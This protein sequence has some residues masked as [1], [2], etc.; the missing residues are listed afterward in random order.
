MTSCAPPPLP[1]P[2]TTSLR[3]PRSTLDLTRRMA[4]MAIVNRTPDSFYDRGATYAL[5]ASVE[6]ALRQVADGADLVDVGGVKA[7]PG[8]EVDAEEERRRIV[9]FVEAIR[10]RSDVVLSIDTFRASV[11][12]AAL[13]AG[14]DLINDTSGL[15]DPDLA[16]VVARHDAALVVMHSGGDLRR[17][18]HRNHYHPDVTTAVVEELA[19]L[20]A[21][22][23]EAGVHPE[24]IVVDPGHDFRK[25]T[26]H[27]LEVTRRLPELVAL[28]RP[29]LVA[30]SNK[31]F[32]GESLDLALEDRVDASLGAAVA[33]LLLGARIVRVHETLATVRAVRMAEVVLGWREP[34]RTVRGLA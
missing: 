2:P 23:E 14:A 29:V 4:V 5:D 15:S 8:E 3:L 33:S 22:A 1:E 27:S 25:N 12:D 21:A 18:P 11:A 6:H 17:R 32:I 20:V 26:L 28:G 7:G 10:A 13:A 16:G 34:V 24:G 30:L 9:P 19:R 31:D